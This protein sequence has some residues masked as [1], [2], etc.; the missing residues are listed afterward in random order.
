MAN[1]LQIRLTADIAQLQ[2][3][4]KAVKK[5]VKEFQDEGENAF[6]G[7]NKGAERQIGLIEALN[8]RAKT[9][10]KSLQEATNVQDI[11]RYN[12]QLEETSKEL[13][14]LNALGRSVTANLGST[15]SSFQRAGSAIGGT[16]AVAIEFNRIIQDAPFG[17][18]GIG[19][20]LQQLAGNFA[21]VSQQ[22]GGTGAAIKASLA[23]IISPVNLGLLAVS[24]L[25][26]GFTAYQLGAFDFVT[27]TDEATSAQEKFNESLKDTEQTLKQGFFNELLKAQGLLKQENLGGR[28]VDVPAFETAEQ[29]IQ[30][31]GG[32]INNLNK[33]ELE[34]LQSFLSQRLA[35]AA[36]ASANATNELEKTLA[37]TNITGYQE[38]LEKVNEQLKFYEDDT[39]KSTKATKELKQ[40]INSFSTDPLV[41]AYIEAIRKGAEFRRSLEQAASGL[42]GTEGDRA[43]GTE[44]VV[45][46]PISLNYKTEDSTVEDELGLVQQIQQQIQSITALRDVATDPTRIQNYNAQLQ[47]LQQQLATFTQIQNPIAEQNKILLDSFSALGIGIASS[48][49]ISNNAFKGFIT[50]V[51]SATPKIIQAILAQSA[52][53][54]LAAKADIATNSQ[55]AG[56]EGIAVASKA[57]NALGPV[58]LALLPV[59]IGGALALISGAFNNIGGGGKISGG[60]GGS[61]S[62]GRPPQ[63]FTNSQIPR[64]PGSSAPTPTGNIDFGN[65][66]G[67]LEARIDGNDIVFVY[68]R[69]KERQQAGG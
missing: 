32:T 54:K 52:A 47:A 18:I 14:T 5:T 51:L 61:A 56:S 3:A 59:F 67:R 11:A 42:T 25:T 1:E 64:P 57:A 29:V 48:L 8:N 23:S 63:I 45:D 2:S 53:K 10:R 68:D 50:T 21:N 58:G 24:A 22:A 17:L 41:Q 46:V 34:A 27:A 19:N 12:Q 39:K 26:A 9:L 35:D 31:L 30:K 16:N 36:R 7:S 33:N 60:G 43:F 62:V 38:V 15:T 20:N 44:E 49:D 4:F 55:V 69:T 40:E 28:L 13:A 6:K 66:Q 37:T 65:A